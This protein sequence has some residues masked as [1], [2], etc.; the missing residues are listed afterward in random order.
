EIGMIFLMFSLGLEFSFKKLIKVGG[1]A[2]ATA[3][4]KFIGC[5]LI[6]YVVGQAM[7]WSSMESIFLGGLLS[8]SS[9]MVVIKT[10]DEQG[11]KSKPFADIVFGTLVVED[12]IAMLL[13]VLLSTLASSGKFEGMGMLENIL[14]LL[15]F[16]ILWFVVGIYLIPSILKKAKKYLNDELLLV[17]SLGLCF[18]MVFYAS[19]VG[20]STALG[21]FVMGSILSETT[22]GSHIEK[23]LSPIKDLFG[24]IFFI[25]VGMMLAPSVIA[26]HWLT[27]LVITITVII[28][29]VIF[30][31]F[32]VILFGKGLDNAIKTGLSLTQLGEFGFIIASVGVTLGV[33]R[34]FIYPVIITVSVLTIFISPYM[35]RLAE[36]LHKWADKILPKRW[37][38]SLER[39]S[40]LSTGAVVQSE[41]KRLI[42]MLAVR[43]MIYLVITIAIDI[44]AEMFLKELMKHLF[45]TLSGPL[46]NLLFISVT[47]AAMLPFLYGIASSTSAQMKE[48]LHK[49]IAKNRSNT[50]PVMG[51]IALRSFI[52]VGI[53]LAVISR[54]VTLAGWAVVVII[55]GALLFFISARFS[56][57]K[58]SSFEERFL[59]N[60]NAKEKQ[61]R[62][63]KP[64]TTSIEEMLGHYDVHIEEIPI[65]PDSK[66]TGMAL[67]EINIREASGANILKI[68]RG[69]NTFLIPSADFVLYP[70]DRIVTVGS[71]AQLEALK[72]YLSESLLI[73]ESNKDSQFAVEKMTLDENSII[74][75]KTLR[76]INLRKN[77][78]ILVS[79]LHNEELITNPTP[80]MVFNVGDT[81]WI[82]GTMDALKQL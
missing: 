63:E 65:S 27:I 3:G 46:Y 39:V 15:F 31:A 40:K 62:E 20:F 38:E 7:G 9:T 74:T 29:H 22:E 28:T 33:M 60:L 25:S 57:K 61:K 18:G 75:G 24:A 72:N 14:K 6:G 32:G 48:S 37:T 51:M 80:D 41:W 12:L 26:E 82:A 54:H 34:D 66:F 52:A 55:V 17:V 59:H 5:F 68:I 78:C 81:L 4:T 77:G 35:L 67:K 10:F 58:I 76:D 49:I 30:S 16:L 73:A 56:I 43:I 1:A 45:P 69:S 36:P 50:W 2:M 70:Y 8:M 64:V 47:L 23:L 53:V 11:L 21:A 71:T 79:L 19:S 44:C 13:M 42:K